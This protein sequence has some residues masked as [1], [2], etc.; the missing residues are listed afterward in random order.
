M[1]IE[2]APNK[3]ENFIEFSKGIEIKFNEENYVLVKI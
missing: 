1:K 3:K 2:E